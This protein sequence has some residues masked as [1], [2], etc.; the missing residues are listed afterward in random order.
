M[1]VELCSKVITMIKQEEESSRNYIKIRNQKQ[2][3]SIAQ[4]ILFAEKNYK[5]L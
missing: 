3:V 1:R 2:K 5:N 4:L